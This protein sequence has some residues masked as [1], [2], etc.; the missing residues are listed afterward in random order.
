[1][2]RHPVSIVGAW[3]VT[4]SAFVFLL[5]FFIDLFGLHH[6]PYFGLLF[7]LILPVLFVFG[8]LLI[9]LGMVVKGKSG[10]D[11]FVVKRVARD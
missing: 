8:L 3:L 4:L 11:P 5:V 9:P 1:M 10:G 7:F 2:A 6:N